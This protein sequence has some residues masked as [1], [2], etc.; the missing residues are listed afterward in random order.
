MA[1][2]TLNQTV[3]EIKGFG[4]SHAQL[5][6]VQFNKQLD[7]LD[8]GDIKYPAFYFTLNR[9]RKESN[10]L[11]LL[12]SAWVADADM[13]ENRN[14][15]DIWNDTMLIACD[16]LAAMSG[17]DNYNL[18]DGIDIR[19]FD[20]TGGDNTAGVE[21][22]FELRLLFPYDRCLIPAKDEGDYLITDD[23][24][25]ILTESGQRIIIETATGFLL[26]EDG[27]Q[28]QTEDG[29]PLILE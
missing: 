2:R 5:Q 14:T 18:T 25:Y 28:I 23:G 27:R 16:L 4:E 11:V 29:I 3:R 9:S 17:S 12:F 6:N 1:S 26:T 13:K 22:D 8:G 10:E 20:N 19:N 15:Q 7:L 24:R 21:F